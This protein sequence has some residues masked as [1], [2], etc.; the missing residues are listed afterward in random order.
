MQEQMRLLVE[1]STTKAK[2][3]KSKIRKDRKKGKPE[4]SLTPGLLG[5][6]ATSST[7]ALGV[8]K[9]AKGPRKSGKTMPTTAVPAVKKPRVPRTNKKKANA[10]IQ[11]P[12]SGPVG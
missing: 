7:T 5:V 3:K 9:A 11:G 8:T 6:G 4:S 10:V 1:Q 12:N 2:S